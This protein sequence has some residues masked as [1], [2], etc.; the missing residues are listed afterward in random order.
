VVDTL[1]QTHVD[2]EFR[3]RVFSLYDVIFN[4]AFVGA[5]AVAALVLPESGRSYVVLTATALGFALTALWYARVTRAGR[6]ARSW[7]GSPLSR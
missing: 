6:P 3:G 5:A 2:D 4:V 7:D 1:V